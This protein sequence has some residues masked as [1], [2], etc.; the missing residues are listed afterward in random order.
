[1]ED[2]MKKRTYFSIFFC[3]L[4][5]SLLP[6]NCYAIDNR[7]VME[8]I[9]TSIALTEYN[10]YVINSKNELLMCGVIDKYTDADKHGSLQR[11]N[12]TFQTSL[13]KLMDDV[14]SVSTV[15]DASHVFAV[16]T[17]GSLWGWGFNNNNPLIPGG[18]LGLGEEIRYVD[19]PTKIMDDVVSVSTS[20]NHTL[21][22]KKDGSLWRWGKISSGASA[23]PVKI[24]NNVRFAVV[25]DSYSNN[26]FVIKED[27][28]LWVSGNHTVYPY[29]T[30]E[31]GKKDHINGELTRVMDNVKTV[32]SYFDSHYVIKKDD[33]LWSWGRDSTGELGNGGQYDLRG[34]RSYGGDPVH[35]LY[36]YQR[37][38]LKIMEN[39]KR[40]IPIGIKVYAFTTNEQLWVW[41]DSW[42]AE[43]EMDGNKLKVIKPLEAEKTIPR[44]C[45]EEFSYICQNGD[46]S[47]ILKKDGSLWVK[48]ENEY[49][50]LGTGKTGY[51]ENYTKILTGGVAGQ[52]EINQ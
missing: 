9:S 12:K 2:A 46:S 50:Q 7:L 16:K 8:D 40:I 37:T 21:A 45:T 30:I 5:L 44:K 35:M 36:T 18:M 43:G 11:A 51:V 26:M 49:G 33:S 10:L 25:G 52:G 24:A 13:K 29:A 6:L 34:G 32:A 41:G 1:M 47:V 15:A 19:T 22:V 31:V 28:S 48:G 39:V 27:D 14:V 20:L 3:I 4:V 23:T 42:K 38:P 17:D